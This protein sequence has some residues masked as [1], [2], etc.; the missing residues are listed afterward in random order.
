MRIIKFSTPSCKA[1][2]NLSLVLDKL[3]KEVYN[4]TIEVVEVD[5]SSEEADD[6]VAMYGVSSVPVLGYIAN[7]KELPKTL[8]GFKGEQKTREWIDGLIGDVA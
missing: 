6:L 5:A 1:C 2:K 4:G 3:N 7:T 8:V